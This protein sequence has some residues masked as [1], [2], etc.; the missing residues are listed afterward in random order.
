MSAYLP[1]HQAQLGAG[2]PVPGRTQGSRDCGPRIWQMGIDK[3]TEGQKVPG[4]TEVRRRA[5]TP[6]PQTTSTADAQRCVESYERIRGR[7]PLRYFVRSHIEDVEVA[8]R[9]GRMVQLAIDYGTFKRLMRRTGDPAFT[10]GHSVDMLG[11]R[12]RRGRTWWLLWDPLD[13][14]RRAGI[15]QGPRWVPAR[16]VMAAVEAFG[17]GPGRCQAGLFAG[18][19]P[20]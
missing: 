18:G 5:G 4:I 8:I 6:G 12:E 16:H 19:R 17:G 11:E 20:R 15:P 1:A 10:G 14:Q 2:T 3:L 9:R 13:D 7:R